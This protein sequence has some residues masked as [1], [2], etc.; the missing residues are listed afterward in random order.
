MVLF[1][2]PLRTP[3]VF[4]PFLEASAFTLLVPHATASASIGA[5]P[6]MRG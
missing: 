4:M 1:L 2:K 5:A 3:Q 6:T